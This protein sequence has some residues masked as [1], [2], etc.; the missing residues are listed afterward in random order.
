[1]RIKIV[2]ISLIKEMQ[3]IGFAQSIFGDIGEKVVPFPIPKNFVLNGV[4]LKEDIPE[5]FDIQINIRDCEVGFP[6]EEPWKET[7]EYLY[8]ESNFRLSSCKVIYVGTKT[9]SN[10]CVSIDAVEVLMR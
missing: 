5:S 9:Y 10:D 2:Q 7:I 6:T 1:M 8:D 3:I 4:M